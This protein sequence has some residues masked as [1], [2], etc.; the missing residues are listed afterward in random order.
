MAKRIKFC[1]LLKLRPVDRYAPGRINCRRIGVGHLTAG[2]V[3]IVPLNASCRKD[4]RRHESPN[5]PYHQYPRQN[6][7][8][9]IHETPGLSSTPLGISTVSRELKTVRRVPVSIDEDSLALVVSR[10]DRTIRPSRFARSS[11]GSTPRRSPTSIVKFG[12]TF[13]AS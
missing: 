8:R 6:S 2:V 13:Q 7:R 10:W 3:V 12:R 4:Q 1:K 11:V 9:G 5:R